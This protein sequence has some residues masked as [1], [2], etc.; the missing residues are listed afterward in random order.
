MD[1]WVGIPALN[2]LAAFH[3]RRK[4]PDKLNRIGVMC[5]F[6]LGDTLLFSAAVQSLRAHFPEQ[7]IVFFCGPQ[8]LAAA[9]LIPGLSK[10]VVINLLQPRESIRLMRAEQLDILLDFSSWQRLTAFYSLMSGARFT[11]GFR[12]PGQHRHR[13]YDRVA[14]HTR[15]RHELDN[16][17]GLL[18]SVGVTE[19]SRP[20]IVPPAVPL[21]ELLTR[22]KQVVVFHMWPSGVRS[23]TREWPEDR[24][25]TLAK[26]L[27]IPGAQSE[28]L[29]VITGAPSD[30]AR[31]EAFVQKLHAAGL[32]AESFVGRD[33]FAS[34]CQLLLHS[35]LVVS[36]NTGVMHLAAI[37]SA[38]T[39]S[40]N[41][42]NRNGR[43]GPVGPRAIGVESPGSGCGYL[44]LGFEH[45]EG[46]TDC[47]ERITVDMVLDAA[48]NLL[49]VGQQFAVAGR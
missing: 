30:E 32:E 7:Y 31:S 36:V 26:H 43:W 41:G 38:P 37:L 42:P 16:F 24:W 2:A 22:G 1:T 27:A 46:A 19:R 45:G 49:G 18:Q 12:T 20:A 34:L 6:A 25:I 29:F 21:P 28:T 48:D 33:G 14:D 8:N 9:E 39:I 17:H 4:C 47:M 13:G 40:I 15:D 35:R 11:V 3:P 23:Y 10:L 44:H 5:S